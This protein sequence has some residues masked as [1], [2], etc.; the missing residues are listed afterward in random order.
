MIEWHVGSGRVEA[1]C[2]R[3]RVVVR[4][5]LCI[6]VAIAAAG[7]LTGCGSTSQEPSKEI[8]AMLQDR[9]EAMN[10]ADA[11]AVAQCYATNAVFDNYVSS[12]SSIQGATAISDFLAD[13]V[14]DFG[15]QWNAE[16]E[17]VQHDKYVIQR[18]IVSQLDGPGT[19][20]AIHIL[21]IDSNGQIAHEWI[22]GW[23]KE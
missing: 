3:S 12:G 11:K 4:V 18:V 15:M 19:G 9:F 23:V 1:V 21:E 5:A 10:A 7:L 8:Q 13:A 2:L 22:V 16:G 14:K 17:P 6:A 20:A